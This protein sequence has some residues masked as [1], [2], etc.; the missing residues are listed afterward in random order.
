M[1]AIIGILCKGGVVIGTDSSA[2]FGSG[3][4]HTIEQPTEK[5]HIIGDNIIVAGTGEVGLDQRFLAIVQKSWEDGI[6]KQT[7]LN[8]VKYLSKTTIADF[9]STYAPK[10]AYGA[11]IAFPTNNTFQLCEFSLSDFQPEFK[12]EA[13]WYVSLGSTQY[14]TDSFLALMREV[15]WQTGPPPVNDGIFAAIWALEHAIS[16]NPGGVNS[17]IKIAVL[18]KDNSGNPKAE[19]LPE[20]A[21]GEHKQNIEGAKDALRE[22]CK[23][24]QLPPQEGTPE[25]PR[26]TT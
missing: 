10:E 11:L 17:P 12:T 24:L 9:A 23:N 21:L 25:I 14:I 6:L 18:S 16:V 13:L 22:Y 4:I 26:P 3:H 1:T 8:A 2:T 7:A 20:A 15:F 19:I 5:L